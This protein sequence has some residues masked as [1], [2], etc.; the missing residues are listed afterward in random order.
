MGD[1]NHCQG[2]RFSVNEELEVENLQEDSNVA[3]H[4]IFSYKKKNNN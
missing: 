2:A 3:Y 1:A 4:S